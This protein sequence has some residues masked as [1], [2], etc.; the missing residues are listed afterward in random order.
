MRRHLLESLLL[1]LKVQLFEILKAT[2][3]IQTIDPKNVNVNSRL[4]RADL[5]C[6]YNYNNSFPNRG[7]LTINMI[8]V[9]EDWCMGKGVIPINLDN[10]DRVV[11]SLIIS[12]K[13][14]FT[15]MEPQQDFALVPREGQNKKEINH[16]PPK[17]LPHLYQSFL[18][19]EY[20]NDDGL[21]EGTGGLSKVVDVRL[22]KLIETPSIRDVKPMEQ[23][24]N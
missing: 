17:A 12:E 19:R 11:T 21:G 1:W 22:E 20:A 14:K 23:V 6:A 16:V 10:L 15:I 18:V 24:L 13:S 7:G 3:L 8:E 5:H 9:E 4:Y 2:G